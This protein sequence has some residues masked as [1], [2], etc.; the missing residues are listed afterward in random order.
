MCASSSNMKITSQTC[1]VLIWW[2][3]AP[4][5]N[6]NKNG[7]LKNI[8][9]TSTARKLTIWKIWLG[10]M[11]LFSVLQSAASLSVDCTLSGS[12]GEQTGERLCCWYSA[13]ETAIII[14]KYCK[15]RGQMLHSDP[16]P[17][18]PSLYTSHEAHN[19]AAKSVRER[20]SFS[21]EEQAHPGTLQ[22]TQ[23]A[24]QGGQKERYFA[25]NYM[26]LNCAESTVIGLEP[27][28][29]ST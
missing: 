28:L 12:S 15:R 1:A 6:K 22:F 29:A 16:P 17:T 3:Y 21:T 20:V 7:V 23:T 14:F 25:I 18:T 10:K 5:K 9:A 13:H 2:Q 26:D 19:G 4:L 24:G 27:C 8:S 11:S